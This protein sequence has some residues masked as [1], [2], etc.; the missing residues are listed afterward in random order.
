[1]LVNSYM[2]LTLS[3]TFGKFLMDKSV[4]FHRFSKYKL[5]TLGNYLILFFEKKFL[6]DS[7]VHLYMK[8]TCLSLF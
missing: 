4:S 6:R 8:G 1:M 3:F 2:Y 7:I 5:R